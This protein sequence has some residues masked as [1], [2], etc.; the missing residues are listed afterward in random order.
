LGGPGPQDKK[1][2]EGGDGKKAIE[3]TNS[4][5]V[6][7]LENGNTACNKIGNACLGMGGEWDQKDITGS[8]RLLQR[9]RRQCNQR[10]QRKKR[11]KTNE[12]GYL[13][14][15]LEKRNQ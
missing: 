2:R 15:G 5:P 9:R 8:K 14:R 6:E 13:S 11:K 3:G 12:G 10:T 1:K 7:S 4:F